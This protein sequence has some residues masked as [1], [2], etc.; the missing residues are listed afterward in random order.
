M[1]ATP[2][3]GL[4]FNDETD[5]VMDGSQATEDLAG[6]VEDALTWVVSKPVGESV[7]SSIAYQNDDNLFF[8]VVAG[9]VYIVD[10]E[11]LWESAVAASG[12]KARWSL[13]AGCNVYGHSISKQGGGSGVNL[14]PV[15]GDY[16]GE[17]I[18]GN[19]QDGAGIGLDHMFTVGRHKL[20]VG[21]T[22]GTARIQW[23]QVTS[24]ATATWLNVGSFLRI[25]R[26]A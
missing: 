15:V 9:A 7:T 3:L 19:G 18:I 6:A 17:Y 26:I 22:G 12:F 20:V 8:T 21:G 1:G 4:P 25:R 13:P 10:F 16:V 14:V 24:N 2:I 5:L 23:A 11:L